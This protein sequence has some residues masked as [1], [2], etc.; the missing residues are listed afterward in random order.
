MA[1]ARVEL[2]TDGLIFRF[3][4]TLVI[5]WAYMGRGGTYNL[6]LTVLLYD[7]ISWYDIVIIKD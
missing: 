2:Y 5:L 7:C 6:R 4:L 3:L 1:Y